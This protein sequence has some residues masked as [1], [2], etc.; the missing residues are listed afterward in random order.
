[1]V[2]NGGRIL[3][4]TGLAG[5]IEQARERAYAGAGAIS[6]P[7]AWCRRDIALAAAQGEHVRG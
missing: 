1:L 3:S 7:G 2:T 4:V 6:F 5:T